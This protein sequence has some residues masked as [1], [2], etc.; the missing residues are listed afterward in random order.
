MGRFLGLARRLRDDEAAAT[1]AEYTLMILV[2]A[3]ACF[4][5][6]SALGASLVGLIREAIVGLR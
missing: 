3:M 1:M 5:S 2:I 6:V 4:V